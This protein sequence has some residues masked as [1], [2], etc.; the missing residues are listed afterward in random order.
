MQVNC[1]TETL[2]VAQYQ[3]EETHGGL[4]LEAYM[5]QVSNSILHLK[6]LTPLITSQHNHMEK[7]QSLPK[8]SA[9]SSGKLQ[10]LYHFPD[11]TN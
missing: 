3:E 11:I 5:L 4:I 9:I 6:L 2:A 8:V 7:R 1:F 10:E